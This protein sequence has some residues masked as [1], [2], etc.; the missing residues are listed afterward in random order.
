MQLI[1]CHVVIFF[2]ISLAGGCQGK[3]P[4]ERQD[5]PEQGEDQAD[6]PQEQGPAQAPGGAAGEA[7]GVVG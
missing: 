1:V 6:A 5:L 7:R 2:P 3:S 4:A